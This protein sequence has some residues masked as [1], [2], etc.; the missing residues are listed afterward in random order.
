MAYILLWS[1]AVRSIIH[2]HAGRWLWQGSASVVPWN[3]DKC[4]CRSKLVST[5]STQVWSG[6][7]MSP[8]HQVWP[9]PSC[10]AQRKGEE[11]MADRKIGGKT[12]SGNGQAWS[13]PSP[14][15][16][17][18]TGRYGGNSEII[19]GAPASS[20]LRDRGDDEILVIFNAW[21]YL[22]FQSCRRLLL[23]KVLQQSYCSIRDTL[24]T[25][26]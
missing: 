7:D 14:R 25:D 1:S 20:R 5:F 21:L 18:R 3:L 19:C 15:G 16:Q 8:V 4:L 2:K 12:A 23:A 9:K 22:G 26:L 17:W 24:C 13:S 11:D 6:L 10:K